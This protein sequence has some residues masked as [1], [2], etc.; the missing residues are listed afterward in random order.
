MVAGETLSHYRIERPLGRGGLGEVYLAEDLRLRRHV[1]LKVL[2]PD[3]RADASG[4]DR[5]LAEARAASALNHPAIAVVYEV[6][7]VERDGGPVAFIAMEY[8]PGRTL[9]EL[10]AQAMPV[11]GVLHLG[12]QIA[13]ALEAAHARGVIHRDVK[14]SNVVLS[15]SGRAKVLDFGLAARVLP[16]ETDLTW[17]R[18]PGAAPEAGGLVGTLA[19]M[20]PEQAL[21][22]SV[23]PRADVF[24]LGALLYELAAGKPA[25]A[26]ANAVQVLD[27]VLHAEP[28]RLSGS[29]TRRA[30]LDGLL[31]RMLA[32]EPAG[33]PPDM[34]AVREDLERLRRGESPRSVE[35]SAAVAVLTFANITRNSEDDWLG[36]G[37]A[38]TLT[39]DLRSVPGLSL[40]PRGRIHE[41]LRRLG[42][43]TPDADDGVAVRVGHEVGA[44]WVLAGGFQRAGDVV[45]VTGRLLEVGTGAVVHTVKADGRLAEIFDLQDR[46]V[47]ELG[48]GLRMSTPAPTARAAEETQVIEAYEAF[49]KGVLNYRR[50]SYESLDRATFLF[51][52]A[53]ALDPAYARAH[54][55]LGSALSSKAD[56]LGTPGL[57]ERALACFRRALELQ[58]QLVRAWRE[59]GGVLVS[60]GRQEE[61]LAAIQRALELDPQDAGAL[62]AMGRAQFIGCGAF[63]EAVGWYER[64]VARSP[65][66]GWYWLQLAH[67]A[68]LSRAF[69]RAE[70]AA[71]RAIELQKQFLSGQEA[72]LIVGAHMRAGHVAALQGRPAE[73]V[74]Q[75]QHEIA[76]LARAEHALRGRIGIEL[77]M[78]LGCALKDLGRAAEADAAFTAAV[79]AFDERV[80]LGADDPHT[81][82]YVAA[83]H[84][85]RGETEEAL[86]CLDK[87]AQLRRALTIARAR[88]E[89][90]FDGLRGEPR[91]KALVG[92]EAKRR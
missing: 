38:E 4:H 24:S 85:Q 53:V 15:D 78:R 19:Y 54:V 23:D 89:P 51:E 21:G 40:V 3:I 7:E 14:P 31:R 82:Y 22:R 79:D 68:T 41:T 36:T 50:E 73:A 47:R 26:G 67:T 9:S 27:A 61:G 56:Y 91:F 52:R 46:L 72:V 86:V 2:R 55:E 34:R 18:N 48:A 60:V 28:A 88:I 70:D 29:D 10:A 63:Q 20:A 59:L 13:E 66:A 80:R 17:T 83:V 33:R 5:L 84:A 35:A 74:E 12:I 75:F 44:R 81:R 30:G 39:S 65:Q 16:G 11:D 90:E 6:D 62:A 1:A 45:R 58:P 8:V 77:N 92:E 49:S 87:A 43:E 69:A 57:H 64:A 42:A 32:K 71:R 76:F 25:F 37:I